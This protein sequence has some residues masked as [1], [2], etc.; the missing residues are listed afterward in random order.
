MITPHQC[1]AARMLLDWDQ[2][3]LSVVS[4]VSTKTISNFEG[5]RTVA[6]P[7]TVAALEQ[8]LIDAG[9]EFIFHEEMGISGV[10]LHE[11]V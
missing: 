10:V 6:N 5:N 4:K 7:A 11:T 3:K 8:S 9:I 2:E 1:K